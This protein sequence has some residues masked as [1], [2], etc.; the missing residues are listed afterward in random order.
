VNQVPRGMESVPWF[1]PD[2]WWQP[3]TAGRTHTVELLCDCENIDWC[4]AEVY[5]SDVRLAYREI[6][7]LRARLGDG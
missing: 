2:A 7:Q 3:K 6:E 4:R 1:R 5:A